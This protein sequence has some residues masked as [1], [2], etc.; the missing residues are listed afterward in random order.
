MQSLVK[1]TP[2][3]NKRDTT[4]DFIR[5]LAMLMI[6]ILHVGYQ[7]GTRFLDY[8]T[9]YTARVISNAWMAICIIA[10][11]LYALL[12]GY[13]CIS[14]RW[15]IQ[16][17]VELWITVCFYTLVLYIPAILSGERILGIRSTLLLINP[18][19]SV[20]W[21]FSAYTGLF[22]CIPFLNKGLKSLPKR[23]FKTLIFLLLLSFSLLGCWEPAQMAQNGYNAIWLI[24]LYITGGYIKLHQPSV[25][26]W[27]LLAISTVGILVNF[28]LEFSSGTIT[29]NLLWGYASVF[30][31]MASLGV[32]LLSIRKINFQT[33]W[34]IR[35][36]KWASPTAFGVYLI[37]CHPYVWKQ[38]KDILT[39]LVQ[40]F[41]NYW[42]VIPI[43]GILL[44]AV[45]SFA[46]WIRI[47]LFK[48][49]KVKC[50]ASFLI[51]LLPR[52]I[53]EL[54]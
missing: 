25:S 18:C 51:K 24:I 54:D 53:K 9:H 11:N 2:I 20:Y 34:F 29:G 49:L 30:T 42:W 37:H 14:R 27:L 16:R 50:A 31:T 8:N 3:N 44:Y 47:Q 28:T 13:L 15:N 41:G 26:S 1:A 7:S 36:L 46:D 48:A 12:S 45:C 6:C 5:I 23:N 17:Y 38:L 43:S 19:T 52:S 10:V 32:F 22:I 39:P 40:Q 33:Y 4:A 21:Y 35:F